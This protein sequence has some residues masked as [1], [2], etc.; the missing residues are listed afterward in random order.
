LA[1]QELPLS[2][3]THPVVLGT[4][5]FIASETMFF[6]ALFAT[7]FNLK[8]RSLVWPPPYAAH[9]DVVGPSLGTFFLL[10]SSATMFPLLRTLRKRDFRAA[11]AWLYAAI[12]GG[13][14]YIVI[15]MDG[16]SKQHFRFNTGAYAGVYLTMTGFHLLHVIA[17]VI[18]M[19]GLYLALH[20]PAFRADDHGGAEAISYYWHFVTVMWLG[21]YSTI[22]WIR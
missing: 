11:Y 20:S 21:I 3:R 5:I 4:V 7:Y 15:A 22:Y 12:L 10:C 13:M 8:A 14:G 6:S 16:Y 18:L 17:G 1:R 2:Y 9:V 19:A